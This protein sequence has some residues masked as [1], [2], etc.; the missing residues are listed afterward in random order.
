MEV[1]LGICLG[2][3]LA[4]ACG[5]RVFVP[6]FVLSLAAKSGS[7]ELADGFDWMGSW[8]AVATFGTATLLETVAYYVPWLDHALAVAASP[9]ALVAGGVTTAA[10]VVDADPLL[11]WSAAVIGGAG[12]AGAVQSA[13]VVNRSA[14]T[15]TTAGFGNLFVASAEIAGSVFLSVLAVVVPVVAAVIAVS[16]AVAAIVFALRVRRRIMSRRLPS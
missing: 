2:L 14:Y 3:G 7:V 4:A 11:H 8:P 1:A 13:T 16:L 9:S 12:F 10:C 15:Q 6:M 5:F